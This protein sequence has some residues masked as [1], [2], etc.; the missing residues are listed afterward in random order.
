MISKKE[1]AVE[2]E[3]YGVKMRVYNTKDQCPEASIV[4]QETKIGH[5]VRNVGFN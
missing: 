4:Y 5:H 1:K 2:F 3:K